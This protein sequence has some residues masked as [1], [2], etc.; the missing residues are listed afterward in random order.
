MKRAERHRIK[1]DELRT[2]VEHAASWTRTHADEVRVVGLALLAALVLGGGL[3]AWQSHRKAEAERALSAAQTVF[4][5]PVASDLP[6][7]TQAPPG[8]VY[9][10]PAEKYKKAQAAFDD[11]AK[12]FG[13]SSIGQRARYYSA[14]SRLELGDT[15]SASK[16]LEDLAGRRDGD[17]LVPSLARLTLAEAYRQRGEFDKAVTTYRQIV[18]DPKAAVPRDH[19]LMR[20]AS[21]F[22]EQHRAKEAGESYRRLAQEFPSSTYASEARRRAEFLDPSG[23][24]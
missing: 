21:T 12:R 19:A 23:R 16:D 15:A 20:L 17:P 22:E 7:G 5:A 10:T 24:G 1:E 18:D 3:Y 13:S 14:L 4:E 2:G 8:Q 6:A 11:V 9:A